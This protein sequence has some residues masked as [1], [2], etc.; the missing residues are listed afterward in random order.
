MFVRNTKLNL[1]SRHLLSA[2]RFI[3]A[4]LRLYSHS[5]SFTSKC[6]LHIFKHETMEV[7][8]PAGKVAAER[9]EMK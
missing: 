1:T 4:A 9:L 6:L 8:S 5:F 3:T 2:E 7:A